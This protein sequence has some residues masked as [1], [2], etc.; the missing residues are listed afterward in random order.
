M[1][2]ENKEIDREY[3]VVII[4][5]GIGG[6]TCG[7]LLAKNG[8]KTLIVEQHSKPGGYVSSY[9]RDGFTFDVPHLIPGCGK[10][11]DVGKI[12]SY[13]SIDKDIEFIETDPFVKFIY[14]EH[15]VRVPRD[16]NEYERMLKK[17]FPKEFRIHDYFET[18]MKIWLETHR[19]PPVSLSESTI[20]ASFPTIFKYRNKTFK[21]LLDEYLN[22]PKLKAIVSTQCGFLGLPP[23]KIAACSMAIMLMA[24]HTGGAWYPR[25][26][27]QVLSDIFA[28]GFK[29]YGGY[30]LLN[31]RVTKVLIE[32]GSATGIE[33][34]DGRKIKA[35]Y[36]ISNADTRL[37]F[38]QL[39]GEEHLQQDFVEK[40]K[41]MELSMS[42]FVVHLGV[43]MELEEL[44]LKYATIGYNPSYDTAEKKFMLAKNNDIPD[45]DSMGFG[46]SVPSL[47]DPDS[48]LAPEGKHCLDIILF[49][50]PY[51]YKNDWMTEEGKKRGE[52]YKKLKAQ[53]AKELIKAAEKVIPNLSKHIE[54]K[55]IATP[56]TYE[57][58]T[59]S[60][61]GAWYDIAQTPEQAGVN[62]LKVLPY[63]TQIDGLYLTGSSVSGSG[64]MA[65]IISGFMT[66]NHLLG[67]KLLRILAR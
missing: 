66:T 34:V 59:L 43:D 46:L 29:R 1:A 32:N 25:G 45:A 21:D 53:V 15:T 42:G 58:Y 38:L 31:K 63:R 51:H 52:E 11:G 37:T 4:G 19:M 22:D 44:D 5:A 6:L 49:P 8:M 61:E 17:L 41:S 56:M 40:I 27:Y 13:L 65:N 35:K 26:G 50:V 7:T 36:V 48:N 39:V 30:L 64:M 18:L 20:S 23:S 54:V 28:N 67:G 2:K 9:K 16:I 12:L 14:P 10:D 3:E 47:K 33:L 24:Y 62:R 60:S 57:R 55:E